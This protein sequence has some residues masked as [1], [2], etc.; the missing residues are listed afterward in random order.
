MD[1]WLYREVLK[2][3]GYQDSDEEILALSGSILVECER[4]KILLSQQETADIT[5]LNPNTGAI[6]GAEFSRS[7]LEDILDENG[8]FTDIDRTLRRALNDARDRGYTEDNIKAVLTVGGSSQIPAIQRILKRIFGRDKVMLSN[9]LDA[10]AKGAAAF[11][12]GVDFYD[13]IQHDYALRYFNS[14]KGDYDYRILV[15]RGTHYP[16]E[17][18]ARLTIKASHDDQ[19]HLGLAIFELGQQYQS[20]SNN[21]IELVF[22]PNGSARLSA[23]IPDKQEERSYFWM[24]EESPTFLSTNTSVKK[25][26]KCFQVEFSIDGNKR[27]L[28]TAKDLKT[29]KLTH[30]N[31]PVIKLS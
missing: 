21:N 29:G 9:P 3:T 17:N 24:N 12:A 18:I 19:K 30:K 5:I 23:L 4:A 1:E 2:Q 6:I 14:E 25:G 8:A 28:I 20:N 27:L 31:Y 10:V 15:K 13:H 11:V 22:D 7:L 26:E 16:T